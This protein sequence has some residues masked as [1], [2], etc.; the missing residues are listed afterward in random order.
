MNKAVLVTDLQAGYPPFV[1]VW[2]IAIGNV[3][4]A[5]TAKTSFAAVLERLQAMQIMKVPTDGGVFTIDFEGIERL[6][7]AG[8][9]SGFERCERAVLEAGEKGAGIVNPD[10][11]DF[12]GEVM[13][14]FFNERFGHGVD[15]GDAAIKP[16]RGVISVRQPVARDPAARTFEVQTPKPGPAL[17]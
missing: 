16:D 5:P 11:L 10:P 15:F 9:A 1:H 12:A 8:V 3:D 2:M 4:A 6:V 13:F 7:A 17:C 14:A